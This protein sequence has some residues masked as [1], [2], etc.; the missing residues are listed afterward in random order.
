MHQI[1]FRLGQDAPPQ[2][3]LIGGAYR[4]PQTRGLHG[5]GDGGKTAVTVEKPR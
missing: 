4:A 2:T 5:N 1:Q 3:T